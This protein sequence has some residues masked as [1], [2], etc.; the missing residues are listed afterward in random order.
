MATTTAH[1]HFG[2][3]CYRS[4]D[5]PAT[6]EAHERAFHLADVRR[7]ASLS[8]VRVDAS[9]AHTRS[10]LEARF[11][12]EMARVDGASG[13]ATTKWGFGVSMAEV[14]AFE[15]R[16]LRVAKRRCCD[17]DRGGGERSARKTTSLPSW[18]TT[19]SRGASDCVTCDELRR[20]VKRW[21]KLSPLEAIGKR[22]MDVKCALVTKFFYRLFRVVSSRAQGLRDC[23]RLREVLRLT[24]EL[25]RVQYENDRGALSAIEALK[26]VPS[27]PRVSG[28]VAAR[29]NVAREECAICLSSLHH[30][31]HNDDRAAST[32]SGAAPARGGVELGCG[33]HFHDTCICLWFH[34]RL[35]CP[36]CRAP[37]VADAT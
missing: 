31:S 11:F 33:H 19:G 3:C 37:A 9:V 7:G 25:C 23:A 22:H 21:E 12:V 32:L 26:R 10:R 5:A 24:E 34:T 27:L 1:R 14:K 4:D 2:G 16:L 18:L 13:E 36:V 17:R 30:H 28:Y 8:D 15:T 6:Q 29:A 20:V 35:N